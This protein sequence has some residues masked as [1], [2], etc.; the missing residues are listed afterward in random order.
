MFQRTLRRNCCLAAGGLLPT[1]GARIRIE[2]G[3]TL[4]LRGARRDGERKALFEILFRIRAHLRSVVA[5]R[6]RALNAAADLP[7]QS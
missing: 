1:A 4:R 6:S 7:R 3:N 2:H 5:L